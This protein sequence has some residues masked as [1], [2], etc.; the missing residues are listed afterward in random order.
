[1]LFARVGRQN[2]HSL[3][4]S[5]ELVAPFPWQALDSGSWRITAK[6]NRS[7]NHT[8]QSRTR[9][10]QAYS[11][12][13]QELSHRFLRSA[14]SDS[15]ASEVSAVNELGHLAA[16]TSR[17]VVDRKLI[18]KANPAKIAPKDKPRFNL[19]IWISRLADQ[20]GFFRKKNIMHEG[21][22][23]NR[24]LVYEES[25]VRVRAKEDPRDRVRRKLG[26]SKNTPRG[27][28]EARETV[29][30][31]ITL[32][33]SRR[34]FSEITDLIKGTSTIIIST[35]ILDASNLINQSES[36]FTMDD[37]GREN[38]RKT[39]G[40]DIELSSFQLRIFFARIS[41]KY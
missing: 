15:S 5:R 31:P 27:D 7:F 39:H 21:I 9:I 3:A 37:L 34:I 36:D 22:E 17:P 11:N 10:L 40:Y 4:I 32:E 35:R 24:R 1:M 6:F 20:S 23:R 41:T 25:K 2:A 28:E 38:W 18:T 30:H 19:R 12:S 33:G 8:R 16:E 13:E 26:R 14:Y 29:V